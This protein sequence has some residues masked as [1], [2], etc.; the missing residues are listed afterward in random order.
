MHVI[1]RTARILILTCALLLAGGCGDQSPRREDLPA[2]ATIK[3]LV[4]ARHP[5]DKRHLQ[6]TCRYLGRKAY[7]WDAECKIKYRG[8]YAGTNMVQMEH[9]R[10]RSSATRPIDGGLEFGDGDDDAEAVGASPQPGVEG[11]DVATEE[12]CERDVLGVVGL[13]PAELVCDAPG[14]GAEAL[15]VHPPHG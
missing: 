8:L 14:F 15:V 6:F 7:G 10:K 5:G 9:G 4:A 3:K 11:D 1:D 13:R 2:L 12:A